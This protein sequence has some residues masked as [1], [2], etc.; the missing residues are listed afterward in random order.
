MMK[1]TLIF[2][3]VF[4]SYLFSQQFKIGLNSS[5]TT[6]FSE[7]VLKG[8][9]YEPKDQYIYLYG[10]N[11]KFQPFE[12]IPLNSGLIFN[13]GNKLVS[14][15]LQYLGGFS[16]NNTEIA[17]IIAK[18]EVSLFVLK[19]PL[20]YSI[21]LNEFVNLCPGF[22]SGWSQLRLNNIGSLISER[23]V[24]HSEIKDKNLKEKYFI[25][26][27]LELEVF[28]NKYFLLNFGI[29]YKSMTYYINTKFEI[30]EVNV[31]FPI[32]QYKYKINGL[33]YTFALNICI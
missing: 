21:S 23:D 19:I 20:Y 32:E 6:S 29:S 11:L 18:H 22:Y 26:P 17:Y 25:E 16:I 24:K 33:F 1:K 27:F 5:L 30:D 2:L 7:D 28:L 14:E 9:G 31:I 15:N 3:I 10:V 4:T 8:I 13:F 12:N